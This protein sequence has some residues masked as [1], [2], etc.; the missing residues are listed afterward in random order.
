[1][2]TAA[3]K[4]SALQ[5]LIRRV[6]DVWRPRVLPSTPE[7]TVKHVRLPSDSSANPGA[8][9]LQA[10]PYWREP[11]ECMDDPEVRTITFCGSAQEG[12]TVTLIALLQS[13]MDLDPAPA[14]LV[15]PDQDAMREMRDKIYTYCESSPTLDKRIP[16]PSKR[17]DRYIEFDSMLCYLAYSGSAQR[18][19]SRTCKNIFCTEIDVWQDDP[20]LGDPVVVVRARAKAWDEH[21]IIYESTPSDEASRIDGLYQDSDQRKYHCP[22]PHCG[23]YQELRFGPHKSG[24]HAGRGGLQGLKDQHG[25]YHKPEAVAAHVWYQCLHCDEP[26]RNEH[27]TRMIERGIWCPRGCTVNDRG[28]LEGTPE[29]DKLNVGFHLW[30]IFAPNITFAE[31]AVQY[32]IHRAK[33]MLKVFYNNWLGLPF[34]VSS[35]LPEWRRFGLRQRVS[36]YTTG[37]VPSQA[38]FLTCGVDVQGDRLYYAVRAWGHEKTSWSIERGCI[39]PEQLGLD[40]DLRRYADQH[41]L[42]HDLV[43]LFPKIIRNRWPVMANKQNP[44]GL[45]SLNVR[46][47]GSDSQYR[48]PQ[49]QQF[50]RLAK[51]N[52]NNTLVY[53]LR[54][55]HQLGAQE[56]FR[57]SKVERNARTHKI[58]EGGLDVCRIAV[59]AYKEDLLQ[60]YE[61]PS[62][63]PGAWLLPSDILS[64]GEDYLRQLVNE[65]PQVIKKDGE[66]DKVKWTVIDAGVGNHYWDCEVY[67]SA[68]AD[69]V[70]GSNWDLDH[71]ADWHS[72]AARSAAQRG[73]SEQPDIERE[74][75]AYDD[76]ISAR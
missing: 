49:V 36:Y 10:R 8:F 42:A 68:L 18:L 50:V 54:G 12:K 24:K 22:C 20:V 73:N 4:T 55:D 13:R 58:Y 27:K 14:L 38:Y 3:P 47:L 41:A 16:P 26:I 61:I 32:L 34:K 28:Q 67:A 15:G 39:R 21:K 76:E 19:R 31:I 5:T 37:F 29:R 75:A 53:A 64:G 74:R 11:L 52:P 1:M 6:A 72:A 23:K 62:D 45:A 70:T 33:G 59:S 43:Q 35:V 66:R 65:A 44:L 7:W 51:T 30:S 17:N 2:V 69:L 46:L 48:T 60:R 40:S 56:L 25:D 63:R 57:F 9:D 71:R